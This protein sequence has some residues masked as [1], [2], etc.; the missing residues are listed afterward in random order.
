MSGGSSPDGISFAM[1]GEFSAAK[2][3]AVGL[4]VPC[5]AVMSPESAAADSDEGW[6]SLLA[7]GGALLSSVEAFRSEALSEGGR[8]A[9]NMLFFTATG[10]SSVDWARSRFPSGPRSSSSM[11]ASA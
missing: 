2:P 6:A 3:A 8:R 11:F 5:A 10:A 7:T 4:S 9:L 1:G